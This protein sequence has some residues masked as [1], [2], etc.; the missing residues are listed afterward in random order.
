ML[1]AF[2]VHK[3][4]QFR[5]YDDVTSLRLL[6]LVFSLPP[7]DIQGIARMGFAVNHGIGCKNL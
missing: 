2:P 7:L 3:Q 6:L 4:S 1:L 5:L